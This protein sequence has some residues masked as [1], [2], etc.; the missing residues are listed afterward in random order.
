M[1]IGTREVVG[2]VC[3]GGGGGPAEKKTKRKAF[4][5]APEHFFLV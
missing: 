3:V 2:C 1:G 4:K 5:R